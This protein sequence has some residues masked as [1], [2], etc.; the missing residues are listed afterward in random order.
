MMISEK[1]CKAL[2][3]QVTHEF[4]AQ[5]IYLSMACLF[6]GKALKKLADYF[7]KQADEEREHG[8][9]IVGYIL[10]QGGKVELQAIDAPPA[11]WPSV[12]AAVEAAVAHEK[13]V[14]GQIHD[15]CALSME[16]KDF[17][18]RHFLGW[19][20]DE[21]VEEVSTMQHL[22]DVVKMCGNALLNIEAYLLHHGG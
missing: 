9:K 5:Q 15:L 6:D 4:F 21:Q 7:R 2:N 20:V 19:F 1:M 12:L 16:E 8:M 13:K 11:E 17:A 22:A 10:D 18:T 14:T 3:Q